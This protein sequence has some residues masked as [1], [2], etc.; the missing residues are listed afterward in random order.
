MNMYLSTSF[1]IRVLSRIYFFDLANYI[2][3]KLVGLRN[4]EC[5]PDGN[6]WLPPCAAT[7]WP[8]AFECFI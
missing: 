7:A 2:S 5:V 3:M 6:W 4:D 1:S 8:C